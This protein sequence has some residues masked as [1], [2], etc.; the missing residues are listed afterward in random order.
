MQF[1]LTDDI[2]VKL[3]D[4]SESFK[5]FKALINK[6]IEQLEQQLTL[7]FNKISNLNKIY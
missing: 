7:T 5:I 2:H 6:I 3:K 4:D 1:K